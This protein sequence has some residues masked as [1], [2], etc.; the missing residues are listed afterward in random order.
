MSIRAAIFTT[1]LSVVAATQ[2]VAAPRPV[3][4]ESWIDNELTPYVA[5]QLST[6]PR[7]RNESLRLVVM[8]DGNPQ[9]VASA[10]AIALRDRLQLALM[11]TPGVRITWQPDQPKFGHVPGGTGVDC[12]A[13]VVHYYIGLE[14]AEKRSGE[15]ELSLRALDLEDRSWVSGFG[16]TWNGALSTS[17]HRKWREVATDLSFLGERAAPFDESQSD[18]LA[19]H[20]AHK[21]GCSLLQQVAGEYVATPVFDDEGEPQNMIEL[22]A[23]NLA[24]YRA[25]QL[26]TDATQAN[27]AIEAKAHRVDDDLYQ[28]W[29]TVRPRDTASDLPAI[30]ASAYVYMQQPF[31]DA[32]K[33]PFVPAVAASRAGTVLSASRLVQL[34]DYPAC[35]TRFECFALQARSNEDAVVF[36]LNHQLNRGLVRLADDRC[37]RRASARVVRANESVNFALR[38]DDPGTGSWLPGESWELEP[39]METYYVVAASDTKAAR[40]IARH[41]EQLP[42]RCTSSVRSG[43]RGAVLQRWITELNAIADHWKAQIDWQIIRVR[44][45]Y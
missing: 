2:S 37:D 26:T 36:F 16:K 39:D 6:H 41:I 4:L 32:E 45:V 40:A 42:Q 30:S 22:V 35:S 18:M 11:D 28:Y 3:A 33:V 7:F 15:F 34:D 23:N 38:A 5:S 21:L 25:L 9:P 14:L 10:L 27:A 19:A 8:K 29:I 43:L 13:D 12:S 24:A 17:Q 20:L 44:N 1:V 31:I